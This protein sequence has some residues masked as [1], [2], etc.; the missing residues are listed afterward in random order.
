[1][2]LAEEG[3]PNYDV[4]AWTGLFIPAGTPRAIINR[5]NDET[6]KISHD[7]AYVAR[8]QG[9]ATEVAVS[10]PEAF[11]A[12][13]RDDVARWIKVIDGACISR[14]GMTLQREAD[15]CRGTAFGSKPHEFS[16]NS[17]R[18]REWKSPARS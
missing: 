8:I 15:G 10:T 4:S 9:M 1:M 13:V 17:P 11:G 2:T 12:F 5:L 3:L 6:R 18:D 14:I 16:R 7:R